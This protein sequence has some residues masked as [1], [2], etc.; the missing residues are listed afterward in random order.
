MG[1]LCGEAWAGLHR[2]PAPALAEAWAGLHREPA[3]AS[4]S[5]SPS[6]AMGN[7]DICALE[8]KGP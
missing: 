2:E 8:G 4:L 5:D 7:L 1:S 6:S 3:P